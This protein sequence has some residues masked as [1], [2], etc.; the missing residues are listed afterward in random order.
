[1]TAQ[2]KTDRSTSDYQALDAAHPQR[3]VHHGEAAGAHRAGAHRVLR[4][5]GGARD[6]LVER[7]VALHMVT[8]LHLDA[9]DQR[10]RAAAVDL[11]CLGDAAPQRGQ[12]VGV[13][14]QVQRHTRRRQRVGR[15]QRQAW[16]GQALGRR[17]G[18]C[19]GT[20]TFRHWAA[21]LRTTFR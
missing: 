12:V 13:F 2:V 10:L 14:V 15:R 6:E 1:M 19:A 21:P 16:H 17:C 4:E 3:R 8:G 7:G 11:A 9:G 20:G 5:V 18:G